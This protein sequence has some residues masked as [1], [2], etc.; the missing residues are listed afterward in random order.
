MSDLN[1]KWSISFHGD[2]EGVRG[3]IDDKILNKIRTNINSASFYS[4][5]RE[6]LDCM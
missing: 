1:Q 5:L 6:V 4:F 3:D 2:Y